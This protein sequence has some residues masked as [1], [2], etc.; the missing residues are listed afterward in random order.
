[1]NRIL[2]LE[3]Q[4]EAILRKVYMNF[5]LYMMKNSKHVQIDYNIIDAYDMGIMI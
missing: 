2:L 5:I 1:M 3:Q 4:A